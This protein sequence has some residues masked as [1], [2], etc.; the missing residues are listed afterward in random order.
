MFMP[1][2]QTFMCFC[3][4]YIN[5][6]VIKCQIVYF[7]INFYSSNS[8]TFLNDFTL[9][10]VKTK[11]VSALLNSL[12]VPIVLL[13][14]VLAHFLNGFTNSLCFC[15]CITLLPKSFLSHFSIYV[16]TLDSSYLSVIITLMHI[17]HTAC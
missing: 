7:S 5:C 1:E 3:A 8:F 17:K 6:L 12:S 16:Q 14:I 9:H 4:T 15:I 11:R 13:Y 10:G 2:C